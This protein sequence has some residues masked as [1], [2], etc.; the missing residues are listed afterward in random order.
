MAVDVDTRTRLERYADLA[1]RVGA[2]VEEGQRV[3]VGGL[4]ENAPLVRAVARAAYGAGAKWVDVRYL[5]QHVRRAMI[6]LGPDEAL[7][8]TPPWLLA[9]EDEMAREHFAQ[10][11][12]AGDPE[13]DLMADLDLA[14]VGRAQMVA[15]TEA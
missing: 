1:V 11:A 14:R 6:E 15:L 8:W 3:S 10:I 5:D 2:N 4:V 13:P 12:I 7:S 9:R